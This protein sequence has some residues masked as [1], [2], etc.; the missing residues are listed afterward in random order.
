MRIIHVD[1]QQ[2]RR[3]G[4]N[5]VSWAHKLYFGL[6]RN[7][8]RVQAFSDRDVAAFE[9]LLRIRDLGRKKCNRRL[10]ETVDAF[11]PDLMILGHCD[12]ILNET[13]EEIRRRRPNI[14]M[15]SC[16]NDP[17]FVPRNY[18]NISS[19]CEVVDYM[20]VSTGE[21]ELHVFDGKRAKLR[22]MPNPVDPSVEEYDVSKQTEFDHDLIF[23]SHSKAF[24]AREKIVDH[25]KKG[26]DGELNFA[27]PGSYGQPVLWGRDYDRFL[28]QSKMC[29]NLNRQ[30]GYHW[31]SSARIAQVVGNGLLTFT[32][33][34]GKFDE[35]MPEE[36]LVYFKDK[37]DLLAKVCEFHHD[38]AKR[39]HWATRARDFFHN[40]I[41]GDLFARY[42]V[43]TAMEIPYSH[44]YAWVR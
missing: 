3:Y 15:A 35:M 29:L 18:D 19:R 2:W 5:R 34:S 32:H 1:Y 8:F 4:H 16:N 9:G 43:E 36:T 44:E 7:N 27:T 14:V 28:S 30:E 41:N 26:V 6:I 25:V 39:Q 42:I 13:L 37:E 10:L 17:L 11:E 33:D 24:T 21:K 12:I 20:F 23:C 22:H 40:E 31:Y 38:D